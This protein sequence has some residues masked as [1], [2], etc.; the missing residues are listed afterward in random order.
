MQ[1]TPAGRWPPR[2][3]GAAGRGVGGRP[4]VAGGGRRGVGR[5]PGRP[6]STSWPGSTGRCSSRP[7]SGSSPTAAGGSTTTPP[8]SPARG[9]LPSSPPAPASTP[10]TGSTGAR[11]TPPSAWSAR[12]ATTPP[13]PSPWASACS[14]TWP[15]A[16]RRWPT[17]ASGWRSSTATSTTATAPRTSSTPTRVLYV[18]IHEW[19]LYPGT[20]RLHETGAG[21]GAGLTVNLPFPARTTGDVYR[22]AFDEVIGPVAERFAPTW[23]LVSL[24]FDAHRADPLAATGP[25]GGRLRRLARPIGRAWRRRRAAP[26]SSW[27]AATTST[28]WRRRPRRRWPAST[29]SRSSR[30][31]RPPAAPAGTW[32]PP[33]AES[34]SGSGRRPGRVPPPPPSRSAPAVRR[35]RPPPPAAPPRPPNPRLT[36]RR[37]PVPS[38]SPWSPS[39]CS[40]FST[41]PHPW[42]SASPPPATAST[43]WAASSA[44]PSSAARSPRTSTSPPTPA[45][46]TSRPSSGAGPTPSG[47]QG[48]RFGTIGAKKDGVVYEITTHR[49]EAYAPDS[50]K[51]EVVFADAVEADLARRDFTVNAMALE[52]GPA[53][54]PS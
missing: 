51:P 45:P 21:D 3:A 15:C 12:P 5:A 36:H 8:P 19:P 43:W 44:T 28:R 25:D 4:L 41:R 54:G 33:P 35:P 47:T 10:S 6:P 20:G 1:G 11:P 22:A 16:R 34:I 18:S 24:G 42:P 9:R 37:G 40:R 14:T 52:L 39:G 13:A 2:A 38:L 48:Q 23:V 7:S 53:S 30:S 46:T 49:A 27:R 32:S 17:G 29:A 26:S 31:R 50:R